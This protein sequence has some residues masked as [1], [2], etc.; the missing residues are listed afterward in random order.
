MLHEEVLLKFPRCFFT[1]IS[2]K[3][4]FFVYTFLE[5]LSFFI[6]H[7]TQHTQSRSIGSL[8]SLNFFILLHTFP[9]NENKIKEWKFSN[10][11]FVY[12]VC[13]ARW[14]NMWSLFGERCLKNLFFIIFVLCGEVNCEKS[15]INNTIN[16]IALENII[17]KFQ[18]PPN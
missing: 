18:F 12:S 17:L 8:L 16:W 1:L 10:S 11:S 9:N 4:M 15:E 14:I 6:R 2:L 5:I 3:Q 7:L 13:V